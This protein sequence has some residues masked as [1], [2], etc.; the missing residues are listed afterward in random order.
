MEARM[1]MSW[2]VTAGTQGA[3]YSPHSVNESEQR[4]TL[5]ILSCDFDLRFQIMTHR[6]T[7]QGLL[8]SLQ[9]LFY[10]YSS[11]GLILC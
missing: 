11:T 10:K 6:R 2:S 5:V 9:S 7:S 4:E 3:L 8:Q 1:L